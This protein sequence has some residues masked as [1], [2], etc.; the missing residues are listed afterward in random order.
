[1][2]LHI[3]E[4]VRTCTVVCHGRLSRLK[5]PRIGDKAAHRHQYATR[6]A[7]GAF[8]PAATHDAAD[9]ER[10][11]HRAALQGSKQEASVMEQWNSQQQHGIAP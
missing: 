9:C 2:T 8:D 3:G 11:H 1:M 7:A 4:P 6:G 10:T 5:T